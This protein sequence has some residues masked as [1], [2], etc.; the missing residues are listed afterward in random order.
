MVELLSSET[1]QIY[2]NPCVLIAAERTE[3]CQAQAVALGFGLN[4]SIDS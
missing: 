3:A 4:V 1:K 2:S